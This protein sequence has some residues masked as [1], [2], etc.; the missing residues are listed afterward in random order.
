M[1]NPLDIIAYP[2][3]TEKGTSLKDRNRQYLFKVT[4]NANKVEIKRAVEKI[5]SVKVEKVNTLV[6]NGKSKRWRMTWGKTPDWKKAIV[7]LKEG[8]SI[9]F[10]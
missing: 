10:V 1:K 6:M 9:E 3:V 2:I 4:K 5:Y 7:T 8:E